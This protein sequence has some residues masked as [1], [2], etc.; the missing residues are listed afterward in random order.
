MLSDLP[1]QGERRS[2]HVWVSAWGGEPM[3]PLRDQDPVVASFSLICV[4]PVVVFDCRTKSQSYWVV[5]SPE[6]VVVSVPAHGLRHGRPD[7]E[8]CVPQPLQE[9]Q[10]VDHT[11]NELELTSKEL[12]CKTTRHHDSSVLQRRSLVEV[13]RIVP[14]KVIATQ[15]ESR[16]EMKAK[17]RSK[18]RVTRSSPKRVETKIRL[19]PMQP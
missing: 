19:R 15:C 17:I 6:N 2:D 14:E 5:V 9:H 1:R 13:H 16:S 10:A 4:D 18:R 11:H 3:A 8:P 12:N 7:S